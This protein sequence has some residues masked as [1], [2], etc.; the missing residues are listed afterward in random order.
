MCVRMNEMDISQEGRRILTK[1][2]HIPGDAAG[3]GCLE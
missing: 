1:E 2:D 3:E